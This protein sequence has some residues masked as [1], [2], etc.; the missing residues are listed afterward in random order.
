M[1]YIEL[2][3]HPQHGSHI[4]EMLIARLADIGFESFTEGEHELF[5]YITVKDFTPQLELAL[6]STFISE[7]LISFEKRHIAD[8]NWNAVWESKYDPVFI[9]DRCIVRA[10][11]HPVPEGIEYDIVIE[12]KMSFGTAHH[13]TTRLMMR[14]VL[15]SDLKGKSLLDMGSG[16]AVLA[17]LASMRGAVAV[18]AIDNDEWAYN[19]AIENVHHNKPEQIEVLLG[20]SEILNGKHFDVILANI[21]RNILLTDMPAYRKCL[22]TG[23]M[24]IMSGFY[25]EDLPMIVQKASKLGLNLVTSSNENRWA[26]V[27]FMAD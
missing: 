2:V 20:D 8:Q 1:D 9:D 22:A 19:N 11:F 21:N 5:A 4:S 23:G 24:L 12:P 15:E 17:I 10:P 14:F 13:E 16:T 26:A 7:L 25:E 6:T 27:C 18:T 3:C